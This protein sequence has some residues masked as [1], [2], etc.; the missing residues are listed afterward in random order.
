[1]HSVF[2]EGRA[3]QQR[4]YAHQDYFS[5]IIP[6]T[7]F[8]LGTATLALVFYQTVVEEAIAW[9]RHLCS[10]LGEPTTAF[11]LLAGIILIVVAFNATYV[12]GHILNGFAAA[13]LERVMV[14]KL[15]LYPFQLYELK[16]ND[17]ASDRNDGERFRDA[18]LGNPYQ[19]HCANLLPFF[20]LELTVYAFARVN[21]HTGTWV[22]EHRLLTFCLAAAI[23]VVHLGFPIW[24]KGSRHARKHPAGARMFRWC[25]FVHI[26]VLVLVTALIGWAIGYHG[27]ASILFILP[28]T[29]WLLATI[30]RRLRRKGKGRHKKPIVRYFYYYLTVTFMNFAY[31]GAKMVGYGA[32]PSRDLIG[33]AKSL[34]G[35]TSESNDFFWMAHLRIQKDAPQLYET[36]YHS[37][38]LQ[39]MNRN[40]SNAT[41]FVLVVSVVCFVISWPTGYRHGALLWVGALSMLS[42]LFFVRFLFLFAGRHSRF[43]IRAAALLAEREQPK[44]IL[45]DQPSHSVSP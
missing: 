15:L 31:M 24:L 5:Y 28:L 8:V 33:K 9:F 36:A 35:Y 3:V 38:A 19:L 4:L 23:T 43:I 22:D 10:Q 34:V 27:K 6:S 18:V 42:Y 2:E 26:A 40:L 32:A 20:F 17:T 1:M 41:A 30:D 45:P 11:D 12:L 37:M 7:W 44:I 14:R 21:G 13:V 39:G 16:W 25:F 29:N